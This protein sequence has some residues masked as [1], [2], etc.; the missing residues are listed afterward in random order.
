MFW[1]HCGAATFVHILAVTEEQLSSVT[2]SIFWRHCGAAAFVY[3]LF[4]TEEFIFRELTYVLASLRGSDLC[5]YSG[6]YGGA[7]LTEAANFADIL[8]IARE[9]FKHVFLLRPMF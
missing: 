3:S 5:P 2:L 6:S 8:R 9:R 4:P 7:P 1:R